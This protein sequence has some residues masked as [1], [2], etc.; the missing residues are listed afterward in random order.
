MA[1]HLIDGEF[2]SDEQ[3]PVNFRHSVARQISQENIRPGVMRMAHRLRRSTG[4]LTSPTVPPLQ[5][6]REVILTN[7]SL[8]PNPPRAQ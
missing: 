1:E 6:S 7:R 3:R 2:Q 5:L 4:R 8:L